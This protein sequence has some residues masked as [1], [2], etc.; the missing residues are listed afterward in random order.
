MDVLLPHDIVR[1]I[2]Q[3]ET[4]PFDGVVLRL[5]PG[6]VGQ[7]PFE[8]KAW[9]Q[10][11]FIQEFESLPLI[12]W[13]TFT[14]NFIWMHCTSN[15]DWFDDAQW[16]AVLG[17]TRILAKAA[18]LGRCAGICFDAENYGTRCWS[19][20]DAA[21]AKDKTFEQYQAQV[22]KRGGQWMQAVQE[23]C[24]RVRILTL[25]STAN[26]HLVVQELSSTG[27]DN[28]LTEKGFSPHQVRKQLPSQTYA[29]LPAFTNGMLAGADEG[30]LIIDGNEGAYYYRKK[31]DYLKYR[32][33]HE[34]YA[35]RAFF[36]DGLQEKYA[37]QV[38]LGSTFYPDYYYPGRYAKSPATY[39]TTAESARWT[40]H[41]VYW[42]LKTADEYV[43]EWGEKQNWWKGS[44]DQQA[45]KMQKEGE[46]RDPQGKLD[47]AEGYEQAVRSARRKIEADQALG[48]ES[49]S[50]LKDMVERIGKTIP[51][52]RLKKLSG[53]A[54]V[55]D[56]KADDTAWTGALV[57]VA[58]VPEIDWK[59][60]LAATTEARMCY[61][62]Q[63]LYIA[64]ECGIPPV[65]PGKNVADKPSA[66]AFAGDH[67]VVLAASPAGEFPVCR[68]G[69]NA[70]GK[71]SAERILSLVKEEWDSAYKPKW[72][73]AVHAQDGKWTAEIAIPWSAIGVKSP[74]AGTK[75][76]I[77]IARQWPRDDERSSW[78]PTMHWHSNFMEP[79]MFATVTLE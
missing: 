76:R 69:V 7:A 27:S 71:S 20:S 5:A 34:K 57:T 47:L 35:A 14:D 73:S 24:P 28:P 17:N 54:P 53:D 52:A 12:G 16:E 46:G 44:L 18:L 62:D 67:V 78:S 45:W 8:P 30:S 13:G 36:E 25:F 9:N 40:E 37:K 22:K 48:F 41:N 64:V 26:Q 56:G 11:V 15:L 4:A 66:N 29:L 59:P 2:K 51:L 33:Y 38:R 49:E 75:L 31:D 42:A 72:S 21:H 60:K 63:A 23:V 50:I 55:I 79:E 10:E 1:N 61:D 65:K 6:R 74:A 58:F 70:V 19:Y 3:M 68:L 39:L 77:N 43:W 32:Q